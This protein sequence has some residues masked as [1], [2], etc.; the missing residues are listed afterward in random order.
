MSLIEIMIVV[1]II[2]MVAGG[3][4]VVAIPKM[5]EA[6]VTQAETGARVIRSAVSQWQ[7]A[8]NEY[9][10]CPTVSQLVEDKQLDSGQNTTDP[11]GQDY[12]ITCA[13]DEV[14]V[15]SAGPDKKAGS[16]DDIVIPKGAAQA[17]G[18][19]GE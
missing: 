2:A 9:G 19:A 3:V 12:V 13:D 18:E 1:A 4:A 11:W 5:R 10:T 8:E 14:I 17:E 6:Q 7:L 15:T 16:K